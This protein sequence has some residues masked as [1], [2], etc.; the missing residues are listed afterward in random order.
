MK[1]SP[2]LKARVEAARDNGMSP[3]AYHTGAQAL[4]EILAPQIESLIEALEKFVPNT[5]VK[6][7]YGD[8][9]VR[10]ENKEQLCARAALNRWCSFTQE[11][12]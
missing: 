4:Y 7:K 10:L 9:M 1:L 6:I 11:E 2:K 8:E 5:E 12:E 3:T